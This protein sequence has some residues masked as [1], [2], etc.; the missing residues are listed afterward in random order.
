MP[1]HSLIRGRIL[2]LSAALSYGVITSFSRLAYD[3]SVNPA[4][5]L[6]IRFAFAAISLLLVIVLIGRNWRPGMT[7]VTLICPAA[8]WYGINIGHLGAVQ[9]IPVS[10]AAPL[11]DASAQ[12]V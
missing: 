4:T 10:L 6:V 3:G 7:P 5:L 2:G 9:F 12:N 11:I 8:I 1:D